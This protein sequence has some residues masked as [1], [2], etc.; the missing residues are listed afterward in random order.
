[1]ENNNVPQDAHAFLQTQIL[2]LGTPQQKNSYTPPPPVFLQ[3]LQ[4][5]DLQR[6]GV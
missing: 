4:I 2:W 5:K 1:M 6:S 3:V